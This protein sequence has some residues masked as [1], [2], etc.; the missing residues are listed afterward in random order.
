MNEEVV[1]CRNIKLI[2]IGPCN[3]HIIHNGFLK[4]VFKL[5]EDASQL[6]VAVYYY[7]NGWPTRWEEFTRILEKLDLPILHFIKHVPSRWLT[8]YNS[9][10]R[11]IENWTA[12]E[13]YFLDFIPKEKSSLLSTNSYK[14]IRE[15]LITP[16][17]KCEVLFLQSS[18]QIFTN[19]TGNMQKRRA[20]CAYYVQ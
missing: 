8:I 18:S 19:Y 6:I 15:A 14:K 12:V 3:I 20:S 10:K 7:F 4:G 5:G 13:K 11:L 1:T 17:M 16:N 2:D 9:S